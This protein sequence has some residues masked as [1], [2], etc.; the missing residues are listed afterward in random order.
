METY[1]IYRTEPVSAPSSFTEKLIR[2]VVSFPS[3]PDDVSGPVIASVMKT[4]IPFQGY[5]EP[6]KVP[7]MT[8]SESSE[9]DSKYTEADAIFK[10]GLRCQGY[11]ESC[12][13]PLHLVS[14]RE[15]VPKDKSAVT[16]FVGEYE[17]CCKPSFSVASTNIK[18]PVQQWELQQSPRACSHGGSIRETMNQ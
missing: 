14:R 10:G 9:H 18:S 16:T 17:D 1:S 5:R 8:Q 2:F 11:L 12:L 4:A 7:S 3:H 15:A 6:L 13:G